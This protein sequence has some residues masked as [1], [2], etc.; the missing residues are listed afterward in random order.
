MTRELPDEAATQALG[1]ALARALPEGVVHLHGELG[2]GKT[3][4][5]RGLLRARGVTGP[6]RSPT[7]TLMEPYTIDGGV[8]LHLDLYR[9]SDPEEL[10]FLGIEEVA[11]PGSLALI[12]WPERGAEALPAADLRVILAYAGGARRGLLEAAG[13]RGQAALAALE[14]GPA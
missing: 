3:T 10:Y 14:S 7:Y 2:A 11:A 4:L 6:V 5:V 1:A 12:E 13:Q 8:V 9:L